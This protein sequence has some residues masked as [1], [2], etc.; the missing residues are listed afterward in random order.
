[1][2]WKNDKGKVRE[3]ESESDG[4]SRRWM[5][6]SVRRMWK[7]MNRKKISRNRGRGRSRENGTKSEKEREGCCREAATGLLCGAWRRL[8]IQLIMIRLFPAGTAVLEMESLCSRTPQWKRWGMAPCR[9]DVC[10]HTYTRIQTHTYKH[11]Q[12]CSLINTTCTHCAYS[13]THILVYIHTH[14]HNHYSHHASLLMHVASHLYIPPL[15]QTHTSW[16]CSA[17]Q[18]ST[19]TNTHSVHVNKQYPNHRERIGTLWWYHQLSLHLL[20][21]VIHLYYR[22]RASFRKTSGVFN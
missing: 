6:S 20:S 11:K 2:K 14:T 3:G 4:G 21:Q 19:H 16:S 18:K 10:T 17:P 22:I 7:I 1:M 9:W 13:H 5:I 15:T 12:A 8:I